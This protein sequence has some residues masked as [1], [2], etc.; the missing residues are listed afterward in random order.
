MTSRPSS[1]NVKLSLT[2][3]GWPESMATKQRIPNPLDALEAGANAFDSVADAIANPDPSRPL[4]N[5][6]GGAGR[7]YCN[8]LGALPG[9]YGE[10]LRNTQGVPSLLCK[11]YWDKNNYSAPTD[12]PP[13]AGGQCATNYRVSVVR[14]APSNSVSNPASLANIVGPVVSMTVTFIGN[15]Q[16]RMVVTAQ[17]LVPGGQLIHT[18][19]ILANEAPPKFGALVR[20]DGQPDDCGNVPGD[21]FPGPNPPPTPAPFPPGQEPG[22]DPDGQPFFFVPPIP[23]VIPGGDP[24]TVPPIVPPPGGGG[25]P[26][27]PAEPG[28]SEDGTEPEG[29]APPGKEIYAVVV[30]F[31]SVPPFA[32]EIEAGLYVSPCRVFLGTDF[33]L[34]L[35]EAGRAMRSGQA[36]FAE[37]DGLTKWRV[38]ASVGFILRVTP[39]YREMES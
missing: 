19:N 20:N 33:G 9:L 35:D 39:Y 10:L 27:G 11:P 7:G 14:G 5:A 29:E 18:Q 23:P 12:V 37:I 21:L 24:T 13:F 3:E 4:R 38:S 16:Y 26:P 31:L 22:V 28:D 15:F 17:N 25:N 34:D 8:A 6:V 30:D 2:F 36:V 32:R 1:A